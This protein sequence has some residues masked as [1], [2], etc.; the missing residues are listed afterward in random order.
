MR[1]YGGQLRGSREDPSPCTALIPLQLGY[2][3]GNPQGYW[4]GEPRAWGED[5][6]AQ[7]V[8]RV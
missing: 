1:A 6:V 4:Q 8:F 5:T 7:R 3:L 2:L